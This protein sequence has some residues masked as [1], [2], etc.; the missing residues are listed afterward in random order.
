M[1]NVRR[2]KF[3]LLV[4][5]AAELTAC[6]RHSST[7]RVS[8]PDGG[9]SVMMP[10][11]VTESVRTVDTVAGPVELHLHQSTVNGAQ[12]VFTVAYQ[13]LSDPS[14][15][16]G[17][18]LEGAARGNLGSDQVILKKDY[19][20]NGYPGI[21]LHTSSQ[22]NQRIA[23]LVVANGRL[24]QLSLRLPRGEKMPQDFQLFF[25]SLR[26]EPQRT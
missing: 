26:I 12:Y 25:D 3:G 14:T 1:T 6:G 18:Y 15:N 20:Q 13:R 23:R 10:G 16:P 17:I 22:A 19:L 9:F 24:Y 7:A 11:P 5:I 21:E 8:P 2:L 4:A